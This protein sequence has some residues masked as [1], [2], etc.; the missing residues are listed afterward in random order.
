MEVYD[1]DGN[2]VE[3]VMT[4]AEVDAKLAAEKA[5]WEEANKPADPVTPP[6]TTSDE[7]PAWAKDLIS[8][9]E[10]LSGNQVQTITK[11]VVSAVPAEKRDEFNKKYESLT[12]YG[13]T[14]EDLTRRAQDAYLLATG[15]PYTEVSIDMR[16]VAAAGGAPTRPSAPAPEVDKAIGNTLGISDED[17]AKYGSK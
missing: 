16:N 15:Q 8:K 4:Q 5:A 14:P 7:P 1:K 17:R 10:V 3:G 11:D 9:V 13:N 12:G 2:L 6:V